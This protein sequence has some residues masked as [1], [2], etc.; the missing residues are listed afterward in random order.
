MPEQWPS[1]YSKAQGVDVWDLSGNHYVDMSYNGIG[2]CVLG[3]ADPEVNAA[4]HAAVD[5]GSM[6]TLNCPEEVELA[7]LL[8]EA[9]PLG[10]HGAIY[11]GGR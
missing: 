3:H 10:R 8:C 11:Q 5:A 9:A 4:V 2:A 7:D 6:S 1:Y